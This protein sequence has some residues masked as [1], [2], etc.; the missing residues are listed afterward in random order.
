M[1]Y[2]DEQLSTFSAHRRTVPHLRHARR[3][4]EL[5]RVG[6]LGAWELS[7]PVLAPLRLRP[8][9]QSIRCPHRMQSLQGY[10]IFASRTLLAWPVQS[11]SFKA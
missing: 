5:L 8:T 11:T 9:V 1:A 2:T 7:T 6:I 10:E 4:Q 3:L